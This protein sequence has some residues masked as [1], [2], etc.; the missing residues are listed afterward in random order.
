MATAP[1]DDHSAGSAGDVAGAGFVVAVTQSARRTLLQVVRT[2]QVVVMASLMGPLFLFVYRYVYGD[3]LE[4]GIGMDYVQFLFPGFLVATILWTGLSAPA[5]VAQ[6]A[7]AGGVHD[8]FRSLPVPRSAVVAGR[9]LADTAVAAWA[10]VVSAAV[11]VAIGFRSDVSVASLVLGAVVLLTAA[12][13]FSWLFLA[14]GL[15][16]REPQAAQGLATFLV[17]PLSLVSSSYIPHE[18]LPGWLESVGANQ[19]VS[20]IANAVR[21]LYLGDTAAAGI[22][23]TTAYWVT[24]SFAWCLAIVVACAAVSIRRFARQR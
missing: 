22:D 6:D 17:V 8:R 24:L 15:T 19:P 13:A 23:H 2:P 14:I 5:G 21:S 4:A 11:G 16:A 1:A 9:A 7:A 12:W 20:V 18:A 3:V 10:V